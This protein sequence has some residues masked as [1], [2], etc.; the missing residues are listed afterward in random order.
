MGRIWFLTEAI[1]GIDLW[2]LDEFGTTAYVAVIGRRPGRLDPE[3]HGVACPYPACRD[4]HGRS[5]GSSIYD[6][7][8]GGHN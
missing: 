8:I 2:H 3:R 5:E 1:H 4:A 7:V 6:D